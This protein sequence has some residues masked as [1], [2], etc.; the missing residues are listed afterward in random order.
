MKLSIITTLYDSAPYIEEFYSRIKEAAKKVTRDYEIIFVNDGSPDNSL[1]IAVSLHKKDKRVRVVDLSRNFGHHRAIMTG[2]SYAT[3]DRV[4]L[5]DCDLEEEPE[6]LKE[7]YDEFDSSDADVIYGVQEERKGRLFEKIS[8]ALFYK[9]INVLSD[10]PI[11]HNLITM[12]LMSKRYVKS[13]LEHKERELF[14][15]GV[16]V[17]TGYIQKSLTVK[18]LDKGSSTYTLKHKISN[19]VNSITSFS[20]KPLIMIFFLGI[21]I[22]S[23]SF[24]AAAYIIIRR[25][26]FG[27]MLLGWPSLMV[28]LWMLSGLI[29]FSIGMVGIY[30][31]KVFS[32]TKHRPYS[33]VRATYDRSGNE[34]KK[35]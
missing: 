29:I 5:L 28:S 24:V 33:I 13:L 4:F 30:L 34:N 1:D 8:G 31:S 23:C 10:Y 25:V 2:L 22:M 19:L 3:G 27:I 17:I 14:L 6:Y 7:F 35:V 18:K 15:G 16:W 11:P 26:F 12:R 9:L 32:E 21:I 20:N